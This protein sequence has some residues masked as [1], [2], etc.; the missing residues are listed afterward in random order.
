V[1][2]LLE[3][4]LEEFERQVTLALERAPAGQATTTTCFVEQV[5]RDNQTGYGDAPALERGLN[6][7]RRSRRCRS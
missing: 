7:A 3:P 5:S 6:A 2:V 4:A 1:L